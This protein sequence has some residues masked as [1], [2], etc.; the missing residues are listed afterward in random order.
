MRRVRATTLAVLARQNLP[1][2]EL[3]ETLKRERGLGA[4]AL[5]HVMIWL[6]NS[7]LRPMASSGHKLSRRPI[8]GVLLPP[9]DDNKV[10]YYLDATRKASWAGGVAVSTSRIVDLLLRD[11]RKVLE[12]MVTQPSDQSRQSAF[13]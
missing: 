2:E 3:V 6:Q 7:A 5:S 10:C 12:L 9:C 8:R 13:H 11:F 1:F 4:A